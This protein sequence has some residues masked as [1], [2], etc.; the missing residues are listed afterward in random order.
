M[1]RRREFCELSL[2]AGLAG[3]AGCS[4]G[5]SSPILFAASE[6]LP[7]ELLGALPYPWKFQ[8][9]QVF[10]LAIEAGNTAKSLLS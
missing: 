8:Y 4:R 2:L 10:P 5:V 1:L 6:A 7:K 9:V 3:V